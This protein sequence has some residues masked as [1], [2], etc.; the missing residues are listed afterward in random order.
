MFSN[1]RINFLLVFFILGGF[2]VIGRLF[3]WQVLSFDE[4]TATAEGQH[5]ISFEIPAQRGEILATDGSPLAS[6]EEAFLVFASLPDIK[7]NPDKLAEK[8]APLLEPEN[9]ATMASLI[10][11]RLGRQDLVW[12]PLKHKVSR[13]VKSQIENLKIGGIGFEEE[14]SR[15]YPEGSSSAQLLGFVGND[16]NGQEKGYFGLE[17]YYD[18]ELKGR[19]GMLQREKDA[20]G[21][22]ILVGEMKKEKELQ[23]RTLVTTIDRTIQFIINEK[24][25]EGLA[26]YG[27]V[28]GIVVVME[29]KT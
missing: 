28:S 10:K 11:E 4:L 13:Q 17:G 15:S 21:K 7:E 2:L 29:P 26:R 24:L 9:V 1:W 27:A 19:P 25:K 18:L 5:W 14:Q 3:F 16:I 20:A 6:N 8:L 23:G 22:P 12:V